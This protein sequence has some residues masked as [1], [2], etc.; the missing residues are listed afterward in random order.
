M[1][2]AEAHDV[3]DDLGHH[4]VMFGRDLLVDFDAGIQR[5]RQRRILDD[6]DLVNAARPEPVSQGPDQKS[7]I[8]R[9]GRLGHGYP[10]PRAGAIPRLPSVRLREAGQ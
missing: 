4:P 7:A 2:A 3:A 5:P 10:R 9:M 6:G 8:T 1:A